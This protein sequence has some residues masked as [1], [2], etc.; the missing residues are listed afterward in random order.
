M[1]TR[2]ESLECGLKE[3]L[4]VSGKKNCKYNRQR[5]KK[6]ESETSDIATP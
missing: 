4:V 6:L 3:D 2:G 1:G 5:T